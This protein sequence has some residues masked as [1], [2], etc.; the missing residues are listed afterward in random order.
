M[1]DKFKSI[2]KR[3]T[4]HAD[5]EPQYTRFGIGYRL[6]SAFSVVT[7]LTVVISAVSWFSVDK[8]TDANKQTAS[9]DIPSITL[10]LKLANDTTEIAAIAPQLGSALT[11]EERQQNMQNLNSSIQQAMSRLKELNSFVDE[12]QALASISSNLQALE[13]LI[14]QLDSNVSTRLQM[15]KLREERLQQLQEFRGILRKSASPLLIPIRMQLFKTNDEWEELLENSI[16]KSLS[17]EKPEYDTGP[18]SQAYLNVMSGQEAVF[19]VQSSGF[20]LISL[21]A[22]GALAENKK[23]VEE[24]SGNFL[25]SIAS[26]ATPLSKLSSTNKTKFAKNLEKL[27]EDLLFI[28]SKGGP[29][30]VIFTIRTQELEAIESA[31]DIL[32]QSREIAEKLSSDA[33]QF[34]SEIEQSVVTASAENEALAETLKLTVSIAALVTV[35]IAIAIAWFYIAR[36][37]VK[38]LLMMVDSA[39][40]LSEG[41]LNSSIYREGNDEIARLGYA[42]MGFRNAAREAKAAREKE[43]QERAQREQEREQARQQQIENDRKAAEEKERLTLEAEQEK[44]AEL[45]RLADEF[46]GSVKHLVERFSQAT[47]N[48]SEISG[49]MSNSAGE[50]TALTQTVASA[51]QLSSNSIN[52]VAS[53]AEQLSASI[54]EISQQVGQAASIAGDAV[55]EAE[56]SNIM[57]TSLNE[58]AAKIGD[59]VELISDIAEQT[60]LL[61][62]NATIEAARAGDA[63]K[64]FAVVASEVKNLAT[65]TAKA[66]EEITNQIKAVQQETG[67]AV[68]AIGGI[69][70]TIGRINEINTTISAAVEEQGAATNEISRSVQQAATSANDV[71]ANISTVNE[72]ANRTGNSATEVQD[73][74]QRLV[75]EAETLQGEVDR[76][77]KQV[78]AG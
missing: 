7:L 45:N 20:L 35:L 55:S 16:E 67:N 58:A 49:S 34:V 9:H 36:N 22:E 48:M 64:G 78:R 1:L 2:L 38:R 27:F 76:F 15:A 21:L 37:I 53:A 6:I 65:Q 69:S 73:V 33:N 24:L 60:N 62:L 17:G 10:A 14:A 5:E 63:G 59:V 68:M 32:K 18:L 43:E 56:R 50:T 61:A 47:S 11:N 71:T 44:R 29:N 28:G 54:T 25:A 57:I 13:P 77:L 39:R 52:S 42:I 12:S 40:K 4:K 30:D 75:A 23:S 66:T 19:S 70:T 41:D 51:S 31:Q 72:T 74:A 46:E 3:K 8:L 26:M